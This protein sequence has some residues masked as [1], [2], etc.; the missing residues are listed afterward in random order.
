MGGGLLSSTVPSLEPLGACV[1]TSR[2]H[3][4]PHELVTPLAAGPQGLPPSSDNNGSSPFR[5]QPPTAITVDGDTLTQLEHSPCLCFLVRKPK[6]PG[7]PRPL[8]AALLQ[9]RAPPLPSTTP[10]HTLDHTQG[11]GALQIDA[12]KCTWKFRRKGQTRTG[13]EPAGPRALAKTAA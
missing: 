7:R 3:L 8:H 11:L 5:P 1:I 4:G 10:G 9:V 6:P 2:S 12:L 13:G